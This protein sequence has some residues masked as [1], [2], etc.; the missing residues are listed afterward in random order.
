MISPRLVSW[1]FATIAHAQSFIPANG[2]GCN[3]KTGN[4]NAGC[5]PDFIANII[6]VIFGFTGG[7]FLILIILSGYKMAI[8]SLTGSDSSKGKEMLKQSIFGFIL[9]ALTFFIIDFF[10]SVLSG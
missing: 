1:A 7:V 9:C 4:I 5:I 3:L 8:G 10:L 6:A 2:G